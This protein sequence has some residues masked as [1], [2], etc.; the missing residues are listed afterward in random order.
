MSVQDPQHMSSAVI[1]IDDE[2]EEQ[3]CPP[4]DATE[5]HLTYSAQTRMHEGDPRNHQRR[6]VALL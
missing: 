6:N 1:V 3:A 4:V 5:L 2:D